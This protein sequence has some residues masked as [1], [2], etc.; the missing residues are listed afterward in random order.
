[1][2]KEGLE[3]PL[4]V[5]IGLAGVAVVMLLLVYVFQQF[6]YTGFLFQIISMDQLNPN[7]TFALN[8]TIR[9]IINDSLSMLLIYALFQKKAYLK[10]SGLIFLFELMV[11]LPVYLWVKLYLEGPSEISSPLLSP[12]HRMIVNP[13]LMIVLIAAF[14]YQRYFTSKVK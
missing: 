2:E 12:I 7:T 6:N 14:Y 4:K 13:L 1:M 3:V 10:L 8:R 11:L 5:R 9:L